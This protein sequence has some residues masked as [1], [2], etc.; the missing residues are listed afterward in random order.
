MKI[1]TERDVLGILLTH[2]MTVRRSLMFWGL[3]QVCESILWWSLLHVVG[4]VI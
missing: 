2:F 3:S 1:C 4:G